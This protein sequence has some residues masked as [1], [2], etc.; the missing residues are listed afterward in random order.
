MIMKFIDNIVNKI[1]ADKILHF[2]VGYFITST[3]TF[4]I[5]LQEEVTGPI[6]IA[7][8]IVGAVVTLGVAWVKEMM[9][10]KFD[11]KDL[12]ASMLGTIPVFV[13]VAIGVWFHALS[14]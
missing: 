6:A 7:V 9:D 2:L 10:T 14:N 3:L 5:M 13:I 4:L 1:G 8:P 12:V 11:K